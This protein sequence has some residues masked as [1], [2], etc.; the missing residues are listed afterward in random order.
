[1]LKQWFE[2]LLLLICSSGFVNCT[3]VPDLIDTE[4]FEAFDF[5]PNQ[6]QPAEKQIIAEQTLSSQTESPSRSPSSQTALKETGLCSL[7]N[8][9]PTFIK[10]DKVQ[11][12]GIPKFVH[13]MDSLA[14]CVEV[15]RQRIEPIEQTSFEC[16][17]F[18]FNH[19]SHGKNSC[20][21]FDDISLIEPI[22]QKWENG[23]TFFERVC[24]E[25]PVKC[26][27]SAYTFDYVSGKK[28]HSTPIGIMTVKNHV[29]CLNLC[30]V[31]NGCK[32]VNYVESERTCELLSEPGT[33]NLIDSQNTGFF[34]NMCLQDSKKCLESQRVDFIVTKNAQVGG[35]EHRLGSV[36]IQT[37]MRKCVESSLVHCRS[38]QYDQSSKECILME[39]LSHSY[40]PSETFD[41]YEPICLD[42]K[43][44]LPCQG[45]YVFEKLANT[46]LVAED[47][48]S[49]KM[50]TTVSECMQMC[51]NEEHCVS[52]VFN[53]AERKCKILPVNRRHEQTRSIVE[54]QFDFYELSCDRNAVL[55]NQRP[56][57]QVENEQIGQIE[58][59]P[60][61]TTPIPHI[62]LHSTIPSTP[63]TNPG[64]PC[65]STRSVLLEKGRT[66]RIEYR[67]LH[68]VNI[69]SLEQCEAL[70][71]ETTIPC[72]TYAYNIRTGD[73]LLSTLVI[74]KNNRFLFVTQPNPSYEL[75]SYL[76][77]RCGEGQ[78]TTPIPTLISQPVPQTTKIPNF[79]RVEEFTATMILM[80]K[81]FTTQDPTDIDPFDEKPR[82]H[83]KHT[84]VPHIPTSGAF[85][86]FRDP[87]VSGFEGFP[88]PPEEK[89]LNSGSDGII[90]IGKELEVHNQEGHRHSDDHVED[91]EHET[92]PSPGEHQERIITH[93]QRQEQVFTHGQHEDHV[94]E[95]KEHHDHI[96]TDRK[97]HEHGVVHDQN[98]I[99]KFHH[100]AHKDLHD[101]QS[102]LHDTH[103]N[104]HGTNPHSVDQHEHDANNKGQHIAHVQ[105][106]HHDEH[107]EHNN[108]DQKPIKHSHI[109][110]ASQHDQVKHH[111]HGA[112]HRD[113]TSVVH[114]N[115]VAH[116]EQQRNQQEHQVDHHEQSSN[117]DSTDN[118]DGPSNTNTV[119][120]PRRDKTLEKF[121]PN[122][123]KV[124]AFCLE[125]GVNV[126]FHVKDK[127]YN[128]AVYAAE[129]FAQCRSFVEMKS[130][131]S[132]FV[133]RPGVNNNCNAF[134]EDGLLT[135]VLVLSND[136]VLPYDVTTK[137][138]FFYQITCDY[139][140]GE[141]SSLVHT[142]IVV[143]G[144]E[145]RSVMMSSKKN[146]DTETRVLLRILKNNRPVTNVYIGEKLTAVVEGDIDAN[147]LRVSDCNATRV[148]G[149]E[150][151]PNSLSLIKDGC[152]V[153][154]QIMGNIVK[155][156]NGL[157]A[158]FTAFRID[159]SDQIDIVCSVVVCKTKCEER[160]AICPPNRPKRAIDHRR[161]DDQITVDQRLRVLVVDDSA[162]DSETGNYSPSVFGLLLD[163]EKNPY[164]VNSNVLLGM[165]TIC[166]L[167]MLSL[168]LSIGWFVCQRRN[169]YTQQHA[170]SE[171]YANGRYADKVA[172]GRYADKVDDDWL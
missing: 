3:D 77:R 70:C 61:I 59:Q 103:K 93:K 10:R 110:V 46:N 75:Y 80:E 171:H 137:D 150:P 41:L 28:T 172:N 82:P 159:G 16:H 18:I 143:G 73:C 87:Q 117:S 162:I 13:F 169:G 38:F 148:G 79:H 85:Q 101:I 9:L 32:S 43:I 88:A 135:A 55:K 40:T 119:D 118:T 147:R 20:E 78:S 122:Q 125:N 91:G 68:H 106:V 161:G 107:K 51:L 4:P 50:N 167:C 37:C 109:Q 90:D 67:N 39:E 139:S 62:A 26:G 74:N 146:D 86:A 104:N 76:G 151:K 45:D 114:G 136:M 154:P 105:D 31:K 47:L 160:E 84:K 138:D 66:L 98:D 130:S 11:S 168:V 158:P 53:K 15:C 21:F 34:E 111:H 42:E 81:D 17:G 157:E 60:L 165:A 133:A 89:D 94:T 64:N 92:I 134:E 24:L 5:G 108:H 124:Q 96:V 72:Q 149:R 152:S 128:G 145:P 27:E 83:H 19:R 132:I 141:H 164:C 123:I 153:M 163:S 65:D 100:G 30:S 120:V 2:L 115:Q 8:E 25:I 35:L 155:G 6:E 56:V 1:M 23:S 97:H 63:Q 69:K 29:E 36:S 22:D 116:Q 7:L 48:I 126:T 49:V 156:Q 52:F 14:E 102:D 131:F 33:G 144:P 140:K 57:V 12:K 166:I 113:Q 95:T 58:S 121:A 170:Y 99:H 129:R 127:K 142:G 54:N 112:V 71:G 44:D